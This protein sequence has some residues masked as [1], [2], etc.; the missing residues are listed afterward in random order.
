MLYP[1]YCAVV[2]CCILGSFRL[3]EGISKVLAIVIQ[4]SISPI[5]LAINI[6][7]Q[8]ITHVKRGSE[9]R[10]LIMCCPSDHYELLLC[11]YYCT[12]YV[13]HVAEY[14]SVI[15]CLLQDRIPSKMLLFE[16]MHSIYMFYL[17]R[18]SQPV[19]SHFAA[20]V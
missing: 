13:K 2:F 3:F 7:H 17:C 15:G 20:F 9:V 18:H 4:C 5:H 10:F 8:R 12:G 19:L 11:L 16:L 1:H 14:N 6:F